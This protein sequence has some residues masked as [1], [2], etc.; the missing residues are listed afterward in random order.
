MAVLRRFNLEYAHGAFGG[1]H[2]HVFVCLY[3]FKNSETLFDKM[4]QKQL[5]C[6]CWFKTSARMSDGGYFIG[7][8]ITVQPTGRGGGQLNKIA[9]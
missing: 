7:K 8:I 3:F 2:K 9:T 6:G 1:L 5:L 4:A